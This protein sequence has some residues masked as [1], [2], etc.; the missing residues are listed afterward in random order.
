MAL[1]LWAPTE[2]ELLLIAASAVIEILTEDCPVTPNTT[3]SIGFEGIDPAD[4]LVQ[5]LNEIIFAAVTDGFLF[6]TGELSLGASSLAATVRGEAA[7]SGKI[8]TELKSATY[9]DLS[10][11]KD[12][13]QWRA[14]VVID[15]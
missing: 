1:E 15:V 5:W 7:G 12:G 3:R 8:R 2:E 14:F 11:R 9:H 13:D 6:D 4:R 10:L